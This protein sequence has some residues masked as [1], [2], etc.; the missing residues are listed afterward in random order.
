MK[1][2]YLK[3][4]LLFID[5]IQ[6]NLYPLFICEGVERLRWSFPVVVVVIFFCSS[7]LYRR[8]ESDMWRCLGLSRSW[9]GGRSY[10]VFSGTIYLDY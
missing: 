7:V 3:E 5:I 6:I 8:M 2:N 10:R 4:C 1:I 9:A